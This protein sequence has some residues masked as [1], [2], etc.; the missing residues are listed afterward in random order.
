MAKKNETS[1]K[2]KF[3]KLKESFRKFRKGFSK[4]VEIF[5]NLINDKFKDLKEL[6]GFK[7]N[8]YVSSIENRSWPTKNALRSSPSVLSSE[9]EFEIRSISVSA[10]SF[11]GVLP[12]FKSSSISDLFQTRK[13]IEEA[14]VETSSVLLGS[15]SVCPPMLIV[16]SCRFSA[17]SEVSEFDVD[18]ENS[19]FD[20]DFSL[21]SHNRMTWRNL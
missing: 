15:S 14:S 9:E 11:R 21:D 19:K 13:S 6:F 17:P 18:K 2:K 5:K 3:K 1:R 4:Y 10:K 16:L 12:F 7:K 8:I 20:Q